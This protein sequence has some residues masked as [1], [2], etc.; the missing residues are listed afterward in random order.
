[1][2]FGYR[3]QR[4]KC[5][6]WFSFAAFFCIIFS[7]ISVVYVNDLWQESATKATKRVKSTARL[8]AR[9]QL[10]VWTLEREAVSVCVCVSVLPKTLLLCFVYW[11]AHILN[12][13]FFSIVQKKVAYICMYVKSKLSQKN[14]NLQ[15]NIN[16]TLTMS[17]NVGS[18]KK[19]SESSYCKSCD[20]SRPIT[21]AFK[22]VTTFSVFSS[23]FHSF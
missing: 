19:I 22:L 21:I 9:I 14:S 15:K 1:M 12:D 7:V 4:V 17:V 16:G 6:R 8:Q 13:F 5:W 18:Q 3:A 11:C 20:F 23:S 2:F 10:E